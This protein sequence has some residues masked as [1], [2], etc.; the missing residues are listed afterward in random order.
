MITEHVILRPEAWP[1]ERAIN[2]CN[3]GLMAVRGPD[4]FALLAQVG[5]DNAAGEYYLPD[6]V[7]LARA[8]GRRSVVIEV[9]PAELAGVN[10]RGELAALEAEWQ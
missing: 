8:A 7:M 10:S 5:N 1:E 6:V 4:L 3:S 2:L 9:E